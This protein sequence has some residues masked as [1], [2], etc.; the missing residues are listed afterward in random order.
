MRRLM[1]D[2]LFASRPQQTLYS[3]L[4]DAVE[5]HG[6]GRR[7]VEDM[8]QIEY[9]YQDLLKMTLMLTRLVERAAPEVAARR[10]H[11]PAAAQPGADAGPGLR[12]HRPAAACRPC[13]TTPPAPKACRPPARPPTIRVIVTSRAFV[14]QAKLADKLAGARPVSASS[15]WKICAKPSRSPTSSG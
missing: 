4:C 13:S 12:P 11:R 2:M 1:Q 10:T 9:S 7:L 5:I 8:K 15:I 3:A 14:E 6:R